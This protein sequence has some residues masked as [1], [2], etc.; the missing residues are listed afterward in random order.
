MCQSIRIVLMIILFGRNGLDGYC[1]STKNKKVEKT[2]IYS[3]VFPNR[4][5]MEAA[6]ENKS[7][8]E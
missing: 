8:V 3:S 7:F 6:L 5:V 2:Y 4:A 1:I